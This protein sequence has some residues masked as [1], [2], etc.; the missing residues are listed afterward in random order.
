MTGTLVSL[1]VMPI[2]IAI[3]LF[4]W[5]FA[6]VRADTHPKWKHHSSLPKYEVTGGA[7][8]AVDGGRQ[9]M[10]RYAGRPYPTEGEL[11]QNADI[12]APRADVGAEAP[13]APRQEAPAAAGQDSGADR[14]LVAGSKLR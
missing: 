14:H 3:A 4:S 11:A 6:V 5:I 1:W 9:L 12:P 7:F 2:V 8:E 10:P 13:A